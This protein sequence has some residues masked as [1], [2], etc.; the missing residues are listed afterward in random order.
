MKKIKNAGTNSQGGLNALPPFS[1][2]IPDAT[3]PRRATAIHKI[4]VCGALE[5]LISAL[6]GFLL[7]CSKAAT[8]LITTKLY[9]P[10]PGS[11]RA[12]PDSHAI[13]ICFTG[14]RQAVATPSS[15]ARRP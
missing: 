1:A 15:K 9:A 14:A 7:H 12:H 8:T 3:A 6:I 11:S 10:G 4:F 13:A 2:T 5:L